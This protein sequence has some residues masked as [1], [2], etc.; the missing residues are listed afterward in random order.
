MVKL[1][2]AENGEGHGRNIIILKAIYER[3]AVLRF[4]GTA[5]ENGDYSAILDEVLHVFCVFHSSHRQQ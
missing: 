5:E 4:S 2:A 3:C 1:R